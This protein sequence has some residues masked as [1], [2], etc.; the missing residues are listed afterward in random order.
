MNLRKGI[1]VAALLAW[2]GTALAQSRTDLLSACLSDHTNGKERKELVRWMFV[3]MSVHPALKDLAVV[4]PTVRSS[5][6]QAVGQ[7]IS[8]LLSEDCRVEARDAM[9]SDGPKAFEAAFSSLGRIAVQELMTNP[10]VSASVMGYMKYV[11]PKKL[12]KAMTGK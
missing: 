4:A 8:R 5:A 7:L 3:A 12:E 9:Q 10:E 1:C 6:D 2:G 11:D